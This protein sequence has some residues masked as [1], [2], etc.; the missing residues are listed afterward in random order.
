MSHCAEL[1]TYAITTNEADFIAR[2]SAAIV[3]VKAAHPGLV[4]VPFVGKREDGTYLDVWIYETADAAEAANADAASLAAFTA[5]FSVLS[6]VAIETT[7]FPEAAV[8]PLR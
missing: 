3:E 1:V 7:Q 5:F 2:R 8:S 6:D 4:S